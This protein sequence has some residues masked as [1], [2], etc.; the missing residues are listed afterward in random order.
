[1]LSLY[2]S[3][4]ILGVACSMY[5][6]A[7]VQWQRDYAK[8]IEYSFFNLANAALL[9]FSLS[10]DWNLAAFI[11]NL[12]WGLLSLYGIYRCLKYRWRDKVGSRADRD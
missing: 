8:R 6:Y 12:L 5:A 4:G 10:K 9:I 11:G 3:A 2:E 1:M 7:R